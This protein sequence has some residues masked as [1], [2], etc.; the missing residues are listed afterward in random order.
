[1]SLS[2]VLLV[3]GIFC[4]FKSVNTKETSWVGRIDIIVGLILTLI[5]IVLLMIGLSPI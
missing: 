4:G 3:V 5:A 1:M 2:V